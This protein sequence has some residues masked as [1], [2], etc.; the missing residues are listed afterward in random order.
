MNPTSLLA[1]WAPSFGVCEPRLRIMMFAHRIAPGVRRDSNC[2][3]L[4]MDLADYKNSLLLLLLLLM[5][6]ID[7]KLLGFF[8]L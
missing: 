6:L 4:S 1:S 2:P 5:H 3:G 8:L 7:R